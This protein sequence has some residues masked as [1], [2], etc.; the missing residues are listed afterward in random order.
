MWSPIWLPSVVVA[1]VLSVS[2]PKIKTGPT[3]LTYWIWLD[4]CVNEDKKPI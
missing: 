4:V 1:L 2:G 3:S